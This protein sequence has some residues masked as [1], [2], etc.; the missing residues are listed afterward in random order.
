LEEYQMS[1]CF[2]RVGATGALIFALA[3][4][5]YGQTTTTGAITGTVLDTGGAAIS[6]STITIRDK[7]TNAEKKAAADQRGFFNILQL[8][9]GQYTLTISAPGF[10]N[11]EVDTVEV[12][13]GQSTTLHPAR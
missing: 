2:S 7:S 10:A 9:P 1:N 13:V 3:A 12:E 11:Y 4:G 8:Q 5:A 6:G